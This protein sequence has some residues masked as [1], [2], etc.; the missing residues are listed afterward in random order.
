MD[1]ENPEITG[2]GSEGDQP[3]ITKED[4]DVIRCPSCGSRDVR[5]SL[6]LGIKDNVAAVFS[7]APVR[8][9]ACARRFYRNRRLVDLLRARGS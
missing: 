6:H 5:G 4:G 1:A 7:L 3:E 8:C 9:R 2:E